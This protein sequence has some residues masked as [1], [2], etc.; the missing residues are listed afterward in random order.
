MRRLAIGTLFFA[1]VCAWSLDLTADAEDMTEAGIESLTNQITASG[2]GGT[3]YLP[4]GEYNI[5]G[6]VNMDPGVNYVGQGVGVT[7]VNDWLIY[8]RD[9]NGTSGDG[10]SLVTDISF[11]N[12]EPIAG[13]SVRGAN[14]VRD[15]AGGI[16]FGRCY[17]QGRFSTWMNATRVAYTL[18]YDSDFNLYTS[19][20][21]YT[22]SDETYV[23]SF[24][25]DIFNYYGTINKNTTV[26]EDC[27]FEGF[28]DHLMDGRAGA[29]WIMRH[30]DIDYLTGSGPLEGHGP[31][32]PDTPAT[33]RGTN[34]IEVSYVTITQAG[35]SG[36]AAVFFRS[37]SGMVHDVVADNKE[38]G[39]A[40]GM[41]QSPYNW[42][43]TAGDY[44]QVDQPHRIWCWNNT[45]TNINQ[46]DYQVIYNSDD[47]IQE[48]RDYF[49]RAPTLALDGFTY[50]EYEYPSPLRDDYGAPPAGGYFLMGGP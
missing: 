44:P 39:V 36:S 49:L 26:V 7:I 43:R 33:T 35:S 20:G 31:G 37:G 14:T 24:T 50:T 12:G 41:E 42:P 6:T 47:L 21:I 13:E 38:Y 34:I 29:H 10:N 32:S 3:L 16:A 8:W 30:T 40:F 11:I 9:S 22:F 19:Y 45:F 1:T 5:N 18:F 23:D 15:A 17:F 2:E 48:D 27:Y 25:D 4:A 28:Y 46:G